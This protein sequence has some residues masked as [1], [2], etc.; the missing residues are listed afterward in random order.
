MLNILGTKLKHAQRNDLER[1]RYAR[2]HKIV[3]VAT[4]EEIRVVAEA[5]RSVLPSARKRAI[6][7]GLEALLDRRA[8][9][10]ADLCDDE[11]DTVIDDAVSDVR[12]GRG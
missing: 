2:G 11:S 4:D 3:V 6:V 9:K 5:P 1:W 8:K 10:V 12:Y 7:R